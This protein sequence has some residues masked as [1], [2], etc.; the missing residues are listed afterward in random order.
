MTATQSQLKQRI[1]NTYND[2]GKLIAGLLKG[3]ESLLC[4]SVYIRKRR[5][6]K[7]GCRCCR[8]AL[9]ED[10]VYAVKEGNAMCIRSIGKIE[11][12]MLKR[13]INQLKQYKRRRQE[14]VKCFK[15]IL[16]TIDRLGA[17]RI[18]RYR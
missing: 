13:G 2:V 4:G 6:G 14:V 18:E 5:C 17:L 3:R 12:I 11:G 10:M 16:S 15:E 1:H 9:H 8:G 7:T